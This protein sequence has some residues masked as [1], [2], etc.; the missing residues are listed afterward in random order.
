MESDAL[1]GDANG[2]L[3]LNILDVIALVNMILGEIEPNLST[4]DMNA[5][6]IVNVL[7]ITLLLNLILGDF[8]RTSDALMLL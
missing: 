6:G 1:V 2:D 4:S 7:D 8:G 5:D 3:I